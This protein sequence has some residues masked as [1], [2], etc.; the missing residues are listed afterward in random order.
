[1]ALSKSTKKLLTVIAF[2][3]GTTDLSEYTDI[4]LCYTILYYTI[5]YY[6]ILWYT[7]VLYVQGELRVSQGRGLEHR[8]I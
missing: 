4:V 8:S 1:M 2:S 7:F 6:T 3:S 5:L